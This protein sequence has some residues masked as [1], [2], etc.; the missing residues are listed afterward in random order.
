MTT[1]VLSYPE[2][3]PL[4]LLDP[5]GHE[6][7]LIV[8]VA[9]QGPVLITGCGHPTLEKMVARTEA[10]LGQPVAGVVGGLHYQGIG[11]EAL[12]QHVQFLAARQPSLVA[13]SP[14]DSG[15]EELA[16]FQTAFPDTYESVRVGETIQFP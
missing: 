10:L 11:A 3:F 13:L 7:G 15:P 6:Q 14:H 8:N 1:G 9:G 4:S 16:A 2:L 5:V 12:Q